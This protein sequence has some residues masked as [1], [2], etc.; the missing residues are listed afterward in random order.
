M[1]G[2]DKYL[3]ATSEQA[4]CAMHQGAWLEEVDLPLR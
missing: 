2:K 1:K 3:I 4:L